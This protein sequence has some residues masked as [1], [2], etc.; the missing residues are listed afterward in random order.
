MKSSGLYAREVTVIIAL[1][2]LAVLF[3]AQQRM[4]RQP[5]H[6]PRFHRTQLVDC[7]KRQRADSVE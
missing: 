5:I 7:N 3:V 2:C 6:I 1:V 4:R